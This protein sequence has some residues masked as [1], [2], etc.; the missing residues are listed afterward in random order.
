[1]L[2]ENTVISLDGVSKRYY[3]RSHRAEDLK[4]TILHLPSFLRKVWLSMRAATR[5]L[6]T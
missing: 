1:M 6:A 4:T 3:L 2:S 5:T